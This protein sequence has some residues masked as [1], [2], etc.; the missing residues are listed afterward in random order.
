MERRVRALA[1][2]VVFA[3]LVVVALPAK[4]WWLRGVLHGADGTVLYL[5]D[6]AIELVVILIFGAVMARIERRPF[7][8]FGL[9]WRQALRGRFW[10]GAAAGMIAL[11][12]LVLALR[13][14]GAL[15][16]RAPQATSLA[17][18]GFG[19]GYAI[20]FIL[21][22]TREEFLYRGYGLFTLTE[23]TTFWFA[24][25]VT[26]AWFTL[27]HMGPSENWIGLTNVAVFGMVACLTLLRTGNLW[28]ALGFHASWDWGQTYFFGVSDSGHSTVPG[29]LLTATVSPSA[30]V[31]LSGGPVGPE[32]S[33]LCVVVLL[34][35]GVACGWLPRGV[36]YPMP[37]PTGP[38]AAEPADRA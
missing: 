11:T 20:V 16:V 33:V 7:A 13:A 17:A 31:W 12:A 14:V 23:A 30:P 37:A 1:R 18:L 8:A 24:A 26:A 3:L 21:L 19:I 10:Q 2:F 9:P 28:L 15:D 25:A 6:H 5:V 35:L 4:K 27:T 38:A 34:L 36:H 22:A 29:H 32:G